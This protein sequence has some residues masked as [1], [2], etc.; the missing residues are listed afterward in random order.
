VEERRLD[1]V[2]IEIA[3]G[4][5]DISR[6]ERD[7]LLYELC[8][9]GDT[10]RLRREFEV[11]GVSG[12]VELDQALQARLRTVL[13]AWD[14]DYVLPDGIARLQTA[15]KRTDSDAAPPE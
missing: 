9:V 2:L 13:E 12:P 3:S 10:K 4:T 6:R 5:V 11:T 15:L 7:A 8:L 1:R 14:R